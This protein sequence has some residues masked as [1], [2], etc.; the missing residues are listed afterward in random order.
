MKELTVGSPAFPDGGKIPIQHTGYG[1]DVSPELRLGGLDENAQSIAI[2]LDDLDHPIRGYNHW[3]IWNLPVMDIIPENIPYGEELPEFSGARQGRGYGK[4]QYSGPKPPFN[5]SHRYRFTVYVLDTKL[6]IPSDS[7][8]R[9]LRKAMQG[10]ILQEG[11][12]I[13]EYR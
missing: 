12:L 13:G 6:N 9:A 10:H 4:H 8:R 1:V 7:R 3:I 5:W 2:V 11:R